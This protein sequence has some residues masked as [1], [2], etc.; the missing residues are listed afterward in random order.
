[1]SAARYC[2]IGAGASGLA[3]AKNLKALGLP[4]DAFERRADVGG[5]WDYGSA[6]SPI[7]K[8]AHLISSKP[9]SAFADF[10]M[11]ANYPDYPN[12]AQVLTYLRSYARH[13]D[14]YPHFRF[15]THVERVERADTGGWQVTLADAAGTTQRHYTG[16]IIA[17]GH[18]WDPKTPTYP[19]HFDGLALHSREYRTPDLFADKRVLV[20]GA[21]N[22]GCDIVVEAAQHA[23]RT[24]H[25]TRR[26]YHYIPKYVFGRPTDQVNELSV[27]LGTPR[28]LRR[29]ISN[30]MIR[31]VA[32]DPVRLGLPKPDHRLLES[33]PLVNS[34]LLYYVGHGDITPKPDVRELCGGQVRFAD[35]SVE[36]VDVIVYATGYKVSFPFIDQQHLQWGRHA[37]DF[38]LHTCHP[39]DDS[40]FIIGMLQPD[41]GIWWLSDLQAQLVARFLYAQHHAPALAERFRQLRATTRPD[42]RGGVRHIDTE[43]HFH[44]I[45]HDTYA[46]LV[47]RLIRE[48]AVKR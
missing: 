14:L 16:V 1:M 33:H 7:Y 27:R 25:S 31:M 4:F 48:L 47:R 39:H 3:A 9:L 46:R 10:P 28:F 29:A 26:G 44:E 17:N 41:S 21:G 32:G 37:P 18:L 2:V 43:R 15:N 5:L 40:L 23:S 24:L 34:Q 36:A 45:D 13:F 42:L 19:G 20:I 11:P 38:F 12:H 35:G 22:S 6:D 8:S 30:L